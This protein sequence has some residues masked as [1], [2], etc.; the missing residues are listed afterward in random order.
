[1]GAPGA[2]AGLAGVG[3]EEVTLPQLLGPGVGRREMISTSPG[4]W[5]CPPPSPHLWGQLGVK[6]RLW[7]GVGESA[8]SG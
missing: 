3:M 2:R 4:T 6:G 5:Q 1:M 7:M 8:G